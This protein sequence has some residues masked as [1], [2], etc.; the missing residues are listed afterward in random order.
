VEGTLYL[1]LGQQDNLE[2]RPL[3]RGG[4]TDQQ[5][6]HAILEAIDRKPARHEF[7]EK[8]GQIVRVMALTGG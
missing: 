3:L 1:C 5:I 7:N 8:P 4:A 2:L 6:K